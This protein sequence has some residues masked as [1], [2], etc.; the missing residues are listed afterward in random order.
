MGVLKKAE[1]EVTSQVQPTAGPYLLV[2]IPPQGPYPVRDLHD[3]GPSKHKAIWRAK[4]REFKAQRTAQK[5]RGW[6]MDRID[7][8]IKAIK[9]RMEDEGGD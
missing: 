1:A 3:L 2:T 5:K 8:K 9:K 7:T 4:L 6:D